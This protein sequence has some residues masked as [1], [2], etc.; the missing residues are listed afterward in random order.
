MQFENFQRT[1]EFSNHSLLISTN[2]KKT[3]KKIYF[4]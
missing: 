4:L 2:A 1:D 3:I